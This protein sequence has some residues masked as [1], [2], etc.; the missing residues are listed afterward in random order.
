MRAFSLIELIFVLIIVG[1]ISS[2]ALVNYSKI[3]SNALISNAKSEVLAI[4][5]SIANLYTKNIIAGIDSCPQIE[6][7]SVEV[8]DLI[9]FKNTAKGINW[10]LISKNTVLN[11]YLLKV[12]DESTIF[13]YEKNTTLNCPF[14]CDGNELCKKLQ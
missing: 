2:F 13:I 6:G 8:F 11:K 7:N 12:G 4:R 10:E 3:I 9:D 1:I 5:A 14:E